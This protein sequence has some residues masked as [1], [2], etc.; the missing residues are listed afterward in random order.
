MVATSTIIMMIIQ[1]GFGIVIPVGLYLILKKRFGHQPIA[2]FTGCAIFFLFV[3]ILESLVHQTI[4]GGTWGLKISSN[5]WL[6]GLY[7][8]LMAGL[9]EETG[10]L[11]AFKFILKKYRENDCTALFYGAGHGGFEA[12]YLLFMSGVNNLTFAMMINNGNT[13]AL[14]T[15]LEGAALAQ[16]EATIVQMQEITGGVFL[17]SPVERLAAVVIHLSLSVLVWFAVKYGIYQLYGLAIL[18]H[19]MINFVAVI[20]NN[21]FVG[22]GI[23]GSIVTEVIIWLMSFGVA[24]YTRTVWKK[25]HD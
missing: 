19:C 10:R 14:K 8:G 11:L 7:G 6:Y 23:R 9:F 3:Y 17:L 25:Y 16:V 18:I 22:L 15:G 5:I 12:F 4:L 21:Y 24:A 20:V 13:A 1:L 2:F